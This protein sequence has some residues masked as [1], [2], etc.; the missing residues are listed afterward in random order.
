MASVS[1]CDSC[2]A[3]VNNEECTVIKMYEEN[4]LGATLK[5]KHQVEVCSTCANKILEMCGNVESK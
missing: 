2:G 4:I 3:I 1:R 5:L